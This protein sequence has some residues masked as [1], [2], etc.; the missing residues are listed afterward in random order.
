M[1]TIRRVTISGLPE[2]IRIE[3][4]QSTV[5]RESSIVNNVIGILANGALS[6]EHSVV[7]DN[8]VGLEVP[9][10]RASV[11]L[12]DN[13]FLRQRTCGARAHFPDT[14]RGSG[15][16]FLDS[17]LCG[18]ISTGI[19]TPQAAPSTYGHITVCADGCDYAT[20]Q[21]AIDA[22]PDGALIEIGQ[23]TYVENVTLAKNV[24]L[25]APEGA[26]LT[27]DSRTTISVCCGASDVSLYGLTV[28]D[29][30]YGV[31]IWAGSVELSN[32]VIR[33]H[34][35]GLVLQGSPEATVDE[36]QITDNH[37]QGVWLSDTSHILLNLA[38]LANNG[39]GILLS[40][41]AT[42]TI[43]HTVIGHNREDGILLADL[44]GLTLVNSQVWNNGG[45]G[46]AEAIP[47]C[48]PGIEKTFGGTVG[49]RG[50][51]IPNRGEIRENGKGAV[52]PTDLDL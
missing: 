21:A 14:T 22:A 36:S 31:A 13:T 24:R 26:T 45:W 47:E 42:A 40:G 19:R 23:G 16:R 9:G 5:I 15:N 48:L 41:K 33:D 20:I 38:S 35:V 25:S 27:G 49:G 32:L 6:L 17:V 12:V 37:D 11:S 51:D 18:Q 43:H 4:D 30:R 1:A 7:A 46:I 50:N 2:G 10:P 29:G 39:S 44:A 8:D 52:C 34:T 28:T 3:S